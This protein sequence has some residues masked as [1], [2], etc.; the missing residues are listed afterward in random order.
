MTILKFKF[1]LL[2]L[3][4]LTNLFGQKT[5][6]VF[7]DT[8][9]TTRNFYTLFH[10]TKR[11]IS[12]YIVIIPGFGETAEDALAQTDLPITAAQNGLLTIIPTFQDGVLSFGIDPLS[13]ESLNAIIG[14]VKNKYDLVN[15]R[16]FIGGFSIGGSTAIKYAQ[17]T[18]VKPTAVFAIDPPLDFERFY[19]SCIR[20]LRLSSDK[21]PNPEHVYMIE[22]IE[23]EFD[24][25]P[26]TALSNFHEISPYSYSDPTQAAVKK[27]G[28]IPLRIYS[29]PDVNW[30]LEE[31][32]T[33]FTG[34]NITDCSAVIN[35]LKRLGNCNAELIVTESKGYRKPTNL[36]HPHAWSIADD[37]ALIE[38]LLN[39]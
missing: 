7:L 20:S 8:G 9:D 1:T 29:E 35:E 32:N 39:Q 36:R 28:D 22:R 27:F 13:Q 5:E 38:W 30:W 24:G 14:D 34:M 19:N 12:G 11:P 26:K 37:D 15:Q 18:Y 6:K 23:K 16:F 33:D 31:R 17:N 3:I 2:T 10:P 21:E 4:V 25:T